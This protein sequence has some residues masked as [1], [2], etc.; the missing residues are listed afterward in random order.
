VERNWFDNED[1][2]LSFNKMGSLFEIG[3]EGND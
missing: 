2:E 3:E 1:K